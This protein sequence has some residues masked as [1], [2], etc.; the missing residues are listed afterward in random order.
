MEQIFQPIVNFTTAESSIVQNIFKTFY[1]NNSYI[2]FN[3]T[4]MKSC[5]I[6]DSLKTMYLLNIARSLN[7]SLMIHCNIVSFIKEMNRLQKNEFNSLILI[8][9]KTFVHK[10]LVE[11]INYIFKPFENAF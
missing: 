7:L 11:S 6:T 9:Q 1:L 8:V 5:T 10:I 2:I 3:T 4:L